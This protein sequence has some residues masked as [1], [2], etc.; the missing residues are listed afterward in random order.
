MYYKEV[1]ETILEGGG[2]GGKVKGKNKE[3]EEKKSC[4]NSRSEEQYEYSGFL[5]SL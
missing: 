5:Q 3:Q 4:C 1:L 2:R